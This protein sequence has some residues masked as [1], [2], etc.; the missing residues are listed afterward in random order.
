[1]LRGE[2]SVDYFRCGHCGFLQTERP[3]WLNEAYSESININDTGLVKRNIWLSNVAA[4]LTFG[5]CPR[6]AKGLD[7]AG[8]YGLFVRLM[9]DKGFDFYWEDRWTENL[10]AKGFEFERGDQADIVTCFEAFEHFE[11][12]KVELGEML[13]KG[14][15]VLFS[16]Q[17][18][19]EPVPEPEDWWYYD[20]E[21][22]QHIAFYTREALRELGHEFGLHM[23]TA[24]SVHMFSER[25]IPAP[26]FTAA[27]AG[28]RAGLDKLLRPWLR[29][30]TQS[31]A[32][33]VGKNKKAL[34]DNE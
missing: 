8:G 34:K 2:Y 3:F 32:E 14:R 30:R 12:P 15:N 17:L 18:L 33:F 24:W 6:N 25:K 23:S 22:G 19:P 11:E 21:N 9:R 20:L 29:S 1:V 7:F 4:L 31:D 13:R 28:G 10:F 27:V 16:T 26:I 5:L